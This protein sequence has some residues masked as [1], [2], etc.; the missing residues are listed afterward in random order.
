MDTIKNPHVLE[1]LTVANE[2]CYLTEQISNYH[3]EELLPVLQKMLALLYL[4]GSLLPEFE[5]ADSESIERFVTEEEWEVI[6]QSIKKIFSEEDV[7]TYLHEEEIQTTEISEQLADIYQDLKDFLL[8]YKKNISNA[9]KAAIHEIIR[10]YKT[11]WGIKCL[12]LNNI[13]H[14]MRFIT[15]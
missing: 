2:F 3:K 6:H 10:L 11:N 1:L 12:I 15:T 8:L 5:Y 7:F 14:Q 13:F 9:Q 4:K